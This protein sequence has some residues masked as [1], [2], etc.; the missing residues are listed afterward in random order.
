ME[1]VTVHLMFQ[2]VCLSGERVDLQAKI[3]AGG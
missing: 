3:E 2:R 1:G